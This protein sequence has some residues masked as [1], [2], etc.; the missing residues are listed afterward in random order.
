MSAIHLKNASLPLSIP[1][2]DELTSRSPHDQH[3]RILILALTPDPF[4]E[5][6]HQFFH[7]SIRRIPMPCRIL[8]LK[9]YF[10]IIRAQPSECEL[11]AGVLAK[12]EPGCDVGQVTLLSACLCVPKWPMDVVVCAWNG[13]LHGSATA[14]AYLD[15][16]VAHVRR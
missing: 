4:G 10:N 15:V 16:C 14:Y 6:L 13:I 2:P 3:L 5:L 9:V 7:H 8:T 12:M 11:A 1:V